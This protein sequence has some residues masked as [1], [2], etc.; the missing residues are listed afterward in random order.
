MKKIFTLATLLVLALTV[1]AQETYR[2]SWDFT[3]WSAATVANLKADANWTIDEKGNGSKTEFITDKQCVWEATATASDDGYAVANGVVIDELKGMTYLKPAAKGLAIVSGYIDWV[4]RD[5]T[6]F[7]PYV[8]DQ[9]LWLCSKN[10]NYFIIPHV[11]PG[12]T[13]KMGIETHKYTSSRGV[14]LYMGNDNNGTALADPVDSEGNAISGGNTAGYADMTW[15]V[16]ADAAATNDDGTVNLCVRCNNGGGMHIYYITVGDGDSPQV[17]EAKKVAYLTGAATDLDTDYA[18][19]MLGGSEK[20]DVTTLPVANATLEALADYEAAVIASTVSAAEAAAVK[21]LIAF[22]PIVNLSSAIYEPLGLGKAIDTDI[23]DLTI[24]DAK[25]AI[26]EGMEAIAYD[27]GIAAVELGDYFKNDAILAKAGD[28][29]AIH[30]HNAGRNAYYY[31]PGTNLSQDVY[32][33]LIPQAVLAAA[34][35]KRAITAVGTPAITF[36]QEDGQSIVSIT[37]ANSNAIY[38]TLDGTDPTT[39]STLYAEPFTL[40]EAKTVKAIATGDGYT[41]S[42]IGTK[43]VT[44]A[45]KATAPTIAIAREAGKSTV[46]LT[47]ANGTEAYFNFTRSKVQA[48]SQKCDSAIVI[49]EPTYITFFAVAEG[50]LQ[51]DATTTFVGINGIDK[52]NVRWDI[53]AH[54]GAE[55]DEWSEVGNEANRSSKVNYM[56]GKNAQSMYTTEIESQDVVKDSLGNIIKSQVNTEEDSVLVTYK[57]VD[58]MVVPNVSNTWKVTSYGQVMTWENPT[59]GKNVGVAGSNCPELAADHMFVNDSI[60]V[61]N[62]MLN[63]KGKASGEPYNATIQTVEAYQGPFDIIV[64]FNNGSAGSYPKVNV[65]YS[66]DEQTWVKIDTL[67]TRDVRLM[68]RN[69]LSYEGTDKVFVRLAHKG[70]NSAG[71]VFDIYLMGNGELSQAYNE[72][73]AGIQTVQPEGA[74]VRTEVFTL[75]GSRTNRAGRGMQIIRKTYA[76]GAVVTKKVVR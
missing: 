37:A 23:T 53:L 16:P 33:N 19:I 38:Y 29:V 74:V 43:D 9:F 28:F 41:N 54:M 55:K 26:F 7:G 45:Y 5:G 10:Q 46:T 67:E 25:N 52:T 50:Q 72:E 4:T 71:Q 32:T 51:S 12:T 14:T 57:K 56:F 20:F 30:A 76:N 42:E 61:T 62:N 36:T 35:T 15:T 27:G 58:Q 24:V 48:E 49:T 70:G 3:K 59:P 40:T 47:A 65:E 8:G 31:V 44:I 63:F 66:L 69:K 39:E 2:K 75:G 60:G 22:F 6:N 21:P 34:K 11:E 64:Y 18:Y 13:V 73:A 17:E 68:K 1:N